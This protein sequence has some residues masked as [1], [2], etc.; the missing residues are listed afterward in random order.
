MILRGGGFRFPH[1]DPHAT[2]KVP[3]QGGG[4]RTLSTYCGLSPMTRFQRLICVALSGLFAACATTSHR[5]LDT[6]T[7]EAHSIEDLALRFSTRDVVFLGEEHDN[8]VG[9]A[10]QLE[11]LSALHQQHPDLILSLEMFERDVQGLLDRYLAGEIGEAEFLENSRPW[12]NYPAHYRP[13]VEYA[14]DNGLPVLAANIPRPLARKVSQEGPQA[15]EGEP[16]VARN[17]TAPTGLYHD[18]F[19]DVMTPGGGEPDE[20]LLQRFF[21]AQ[22]YKDD[23]M[24]ES[25]SD[26]LGEAWQDG[27]R[28]IVVH[29]CGKFH[30]DFGEGTVSRLRSRLPEL[31]VAVVTMESGELRH[32]DVTE[33]PRGDVIWTV[34]VMKKEPRPAATSAGPHQPRHA[35]PEGDAEEE[36]GS[37]EEGSR[38]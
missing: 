33:D 9:H 5:S 26:S 22:C 10:M 17:S 27:R 1:R 23:T 29:V 4:L 15:I 21:A 18:L 20:E 32:A 35:K 30:S 28:P 2:A 3:G 13:L 36:T 38:P 16:F 25:I 31:R 19:W 8:D 14:R 6:V 34:P 24:A 12:P 11:M 37:D 7:G